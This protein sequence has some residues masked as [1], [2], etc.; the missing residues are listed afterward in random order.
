MTAAGKDPLNL[1][2][3]YLAGVLHRVPTYLFL[4]SAFSFLIRGSKWLLRKEKNKTG[5]LHMCYNFSK[6]KDMLILA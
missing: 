3:D 2:S 4:V 6:N 1:Y 5:S